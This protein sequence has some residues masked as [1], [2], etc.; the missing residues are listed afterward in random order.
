MK[1]GE[2][3]LA[4]LGKREGSI[5]SGIRPVIIVSNDK[6]NEHSP[7]VNVIPITSNINKNNLPVHV[8]IGIE[9]GLLK[10]SVALVEQ[11]TTIDKTMLIKK[12]GQCTYQTMERIN[13]AILIQKGLI[14]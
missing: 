5:Q 3:W 12:I 6:N 11:D 2:I 4:N 14:A 9:C 1:R 13:K 8:Y 10:P 7:T